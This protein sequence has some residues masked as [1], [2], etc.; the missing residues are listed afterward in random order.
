[1][2]VLPRVVAAKPLMGALVIVYLYELVKALL[3]LKEVVGGRFGG[4][5]LQR[6]CGELLFFITIQPVKILN[7]QP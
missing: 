6:V 3:L 7:L 4:F 5:L 2:S 1:M